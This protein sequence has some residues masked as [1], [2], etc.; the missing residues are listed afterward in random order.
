MKIDSAKVDGIIPET[1]DSNGPQQ[2]AVP[3]K[4]SETVAPTEEIFHNAILGI[5]FGSSKIVTSMMQVNSKFPI[6]IR[7]ETSDL[8]TTNLCGF[9]G[10]QR[11]IGELASGQS[12]MH[13]HTC[14]EK[15]NLLLQRAE[16]AVSEPTC[17]RNGTLP[18][19]F[20]PPGETDEG[21]TPPARF[22]LSYD[23]KNEIFYAEQLYSMIL[24]TIQQYC[25]SANSEFDNDSILES[26]FLVPESASTQLLHAI[27]TAASLSKMNILG[28]VT[29]SEALTMAYALKHPKDVADNAAP[30][31]VLFIDMGESGFTL[32]L[33]KFTKDRGEI[34]DVVSL[35][36]GGS[37]FDIKLFQYCKT[38]IKANYDEDPDTNWRLCRRLFIALN[39]AKVI[40][41]TIP[42]TQIALSVGE[43]DIRIP[44]TR[45][46]LQD[47]CVEELTTISITVK[48]FLAKYSDLT[49]D[50][51]EVV[52]G[53]TRM[54][55]LMQTI[56][57]CLNGVPIRHTLDS[58]LD[59]SVGTV[60]VGSSRTRGFQIK[61]EIIHPNP[62]AFEIDVTNGHTLTQD[63]REECI[64]TE[65]RMSKMDDDIKARSVLRN[66]I[67]TL[68]FEMRDA[69]SNSNYAQFLDD[70]KKKEEFEQYL[71]ET[72]IWTEDCSD[73][74][75]EVLADKQKEI[76]EKRL[77]LVPKLDVRLKEIESEKQRNAAEA[78]SKKIETSTS[79]STR[80]MTNKEKL[81]S[82]KEKKEQGTTHFVNLDYPAAV[83]RY[84]QAIEDV[85]TM[86][87]ETPDQLEESKSLKLACYLNI[88]QCLLKVQSYDKAIENC[89]YA[90][91][92]DPENAKAFFRRG[93]ALFAKKEYELAE[94]Y[95]LFS[96][97]SWFILLFKSS[98]VF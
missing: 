1:Q 64:A 29:V 37:N 56:E 60:G 20:V 75:R 47:L 94:N 21:E 74:S 36:I 12:Q 33:S 42:Q 43:T 5:D 14:V 57:S 34:V 69:L 71:Q 44:I 2:P 32:F 24:N 65:E 46:Q 18:I 9:K 78:A 50:S 52:G 45:V 67:E 90:L 35:P 63:Q 93:S 15:I 62:T 27:N 54:P 92:I 96:V 10:N 82:A 55:I 68:L 17:E 86:F 6:I 84:T 41:S 83:K 31:H 49:I 70:S 98:T 13:P 91:T 8:F 3:V 66:N 40:L 81:E 59:A 73:L 25:K 58:D 61:I 53:V 72:S 16:V 89:K 48:E 22:Q 39:K 97:D 85:S 80:H 88:A 7:N 23:G 11:L 30:K 76:L 87:D 95:F 4:I 38:Y 79:R 26:Y 51:L 77:L 28:F 19:T